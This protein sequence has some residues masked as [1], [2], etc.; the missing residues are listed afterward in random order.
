M[1]INEM[2]I[3]SCLTKSTGK[4]YDVIKVVSNG[5]DYQIGPYYLKTARMV[6]SDFYRE[7]AEKV[8]L[9]DRETGELID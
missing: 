7:G 3:A 9:M 8:F 5:E 1:S 4:T 6:Q 2:F